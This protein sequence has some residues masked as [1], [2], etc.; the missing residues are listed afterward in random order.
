MK[1]E[2]SFVE[3]R[4]KSILETVNNNPEVRVDQLAELFNVSPITIR[5]DL[6]FLEDRKKIVRFYGGATANKS[7]EQALDE[8]NIYRTLIAKYTATLIED[9]DILFMNTSSNALQVW[10]TWRPRSD[11]DHQQTARRFMPNASPV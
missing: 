5:R 10:S 2:R 1:R 8:I 11:G 4:R 9:K 6:Q 7:E 3:N